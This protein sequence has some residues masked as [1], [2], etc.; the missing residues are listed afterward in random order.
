MT[1]GQSRNP[2]APQ[3]PTNAETTSGG[4]RKQMPADARAF[5]QKKRLV[6]RPFLIPPR[7]LSRVINSDY[8]DLISAYLPHISAGLY[9]LEHRGQ[10]NASG[11]LSQEKFLKQNMDT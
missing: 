10:K 8:D 2:R 3:Q 6:R 5:G 1:T 4:D 9:V 11:G 7:V